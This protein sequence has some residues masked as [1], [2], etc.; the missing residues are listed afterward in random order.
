MKIV[1]PAQFDHALNAP[2]G[3]S[4]TR[5]GP[6]AALPV[7]L[8]QT[9]AGLAQ[10]SFWRPSQDEIAQLALGHS[11]ALWVVGPHPVVSISVEDVE[12]QKIPKEILGG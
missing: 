12:L 3:W 7:Q 9:E 4:P 11:I 2:S 8:R 10:V 1:I 5:H 6:C